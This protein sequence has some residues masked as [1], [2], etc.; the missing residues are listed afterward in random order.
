[1][2]INH[3]LSR[4]RHTSKRAPRRRLP[5]STWLVGVLVVVG[6]IAVSIEP[7]NAGSLGVSSPSS[8]AAASMPDE[9]MAVEMVDM[10]VE[11]WDVAD[12]AVGLFEEAG[13]DL[14]PIRFV[15]HGGATEP[16]QGRAGTHREIE[17]VSVIDI[18]ATEV[19]RPVQVMVLHETAHAWTAATLIPEPK[20][21]FQELRS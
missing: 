16:C 1:M 21:A 10:P 4:V 5:L 15:H 14:P 19:G 3:R 17:G 12:W 6:G 8:V 2:G 7:E 13:L 11:L 20:L 18:C 9:V